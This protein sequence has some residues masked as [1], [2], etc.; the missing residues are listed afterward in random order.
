MRHHGEIIRR[1]GE[2]QRSFE[3]LVRTEAAVQP[4]TTPV[5]AADQRRSRLRLF[6]Q[7]RATMG[8][9]VGYNPANTRFIDYRQQR[10]VQTARKEGERSGRARGARQRADQVPTLGERPLAQRAVHV[11]IGVGVGRQEAGPGGVGVNI[12]G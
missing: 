7:Q 3:A 9:H 4:K 1:A 8:T 12:G 10:F 11:G 2:V 5:V 6:A